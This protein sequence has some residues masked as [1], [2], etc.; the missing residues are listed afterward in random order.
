LVKDGLLETLAE[1]IDLRDPYVY[2][3]SQQ[4]TR[5]AVLIA[6]QMG[7][8]PE[9]IEII[10]KSSLMHDVGK[11]GF[12]SCLIA[13]PSR[14][15]ESEFDVVKQH[16]IVGA[17]LLRKSH[18]LQSLIPIVLHHHERFDGKGYPDHLKGTDIPLQARIICLADAVEAMASGRPYHRPMSLEEILE[19]I[20]RCSGSQFDPAMVRAFEKLAEKKGPAILLV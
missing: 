2:G 14:L 9:Q 3:H 11:M 20:R 7:L 17:D 4:V 15:T 16:V 6:G 12:D 8:S 18:S 13:K 10:R 5:Y 1:V 19:E